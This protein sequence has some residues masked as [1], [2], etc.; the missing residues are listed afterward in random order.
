MRIRST[1]LRAVAAL[2]V[3]LLSLAAF[4][5]PLSASP[6]CGSGSCSKSAAPVRRADFPPVSHSPPAPE[7][8]PHAGQVTATAQYFFEIVYQPHETRLYLYNSAKA[9]LSLQGATGEIVMHVRGNPQWFRF[10]LH[11]VPA[12]AA[13]GGVDYLIAPADV[14]RIRDGDMQVAFHLANLPASQET[15]ATFVQ[16]FALSRSAVNVVSTVPATVTQV[17]LQETDRA[18]IARQRVCPVMS[19][20]LGE[21]GEPI[22]LWV[23]DQ[24]VYVCCAGCVEKVRQQPEHY[25]AKAAELRGGG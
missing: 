15:V 9:P 21:H 17:A 13:T 19:T 25:L 24:P 10:P 16:R 5:P 12:S 22:K 11:H 8:P 18:A 20:A 7:R 4:T 6:G 23:G 14:S 1:C 2:T 3:G